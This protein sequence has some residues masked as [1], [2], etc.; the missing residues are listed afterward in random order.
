VPTTYPPVPGNMELTGL[1]WD[2]P[3]T[4]YISFSFLLD[5]VGDNITSYYLHFAWFV[6]A[7]NFDPL[8]RS[9][10]VFFSWVLMKTAFA[11]SEHQVSVSVP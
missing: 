2:S 7:R 1:L 8:P 4:S 11:S 9:L 5:F 3:E 6:L 10:L